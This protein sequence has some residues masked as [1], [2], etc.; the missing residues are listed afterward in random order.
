MLSALSD[1][2][3][4][5]GQPLVGLSA[6]VGDS[7]TVAGSLALTVTSSN[8]TLLPDDQITLGGSGASRTLRLQPVTGK[9]GT[10]SITVT[11]SKG[12]LATQR[13]FTY[14]VAW[15]ASYHPMKGTSFL[16]RPMTA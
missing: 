10:T 8:S 11:V 5:P 2:S 14:T 3:S 15:Q 7:E 6:T 12:S 9:T 1:Q 16:S 4:A 13:S